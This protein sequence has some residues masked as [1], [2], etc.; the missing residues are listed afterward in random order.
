MTHAN[1]NGTTSVYISCPIVSEIIGT[2]KNQP[3]QAK[4]RYSGLFS[5]SESA[6]NTNAKNSNIKTVVDNWYANNILG[7]Y[8]GT[9]SD[10]QLLENYLSDEVFCNDRTS[11][12]NN[13]PLPNNA[14]SSYV[15]GPNS[16]NTASTRVPS[17]K[18]PNLARDGFTLKTS[19]TNSTVTAGQL[20]NNMLEYP[21]GLITIDEAAFAG[22][23]SGLLNQNYYLDTG[24]YYWTMSPYNFYSSHANADVWYVYSTGSLST[25]Y[26]AAGYGVRPVLNLKSGILYSSGSGTESDPYVVEL[27]ST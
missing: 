19:D 6:S 15:Y 2:V 7:K 13:F 24:Q 14:S 12:S 4:V 18:C 25:N 8:D 1:S 20:G 27:P 26:T 10:K 22:G 23:R 11:S 5:A 21:V 16:R 9:D 17:L 3:T